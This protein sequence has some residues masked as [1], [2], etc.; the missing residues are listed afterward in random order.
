[1]AVELH[2]QIILNIFLLTV[3]N[4]EMDEIIRPRFRSPRT[5][6]SI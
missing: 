6:Y 5:L 3:Y 4:K 2:E 1:M